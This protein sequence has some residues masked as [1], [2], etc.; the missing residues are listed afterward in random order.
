MEIAYTFLESVR[1]TQLKGIRGSPYK[2]RA[3]VRIPRV[4]SRL[5]CAQELASA[6]VELSSDELRAAAERERARL[7]GPAGEI[8]GIGDSQGVGADSAPGFE[9]LVGKTIEVRWRYHTV[10]NGHRK[11]VLAHMR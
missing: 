2:L 8:D 11:Q 10:E 9:T 5:A 3:F 4:P 6:K 7:E 1:T